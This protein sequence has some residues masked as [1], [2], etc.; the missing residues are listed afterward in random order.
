MHIVGLINRECE[1]AKMRELW[2][3][4]GPALDPAVEG[5]TSVRLILRRRF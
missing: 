4:D 2:E 3:K 1:S 5:E